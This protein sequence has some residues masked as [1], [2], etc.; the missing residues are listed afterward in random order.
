MKRMWELKQAAEPDM[1]EIFIYG[2]VTDTVIDWVNCIYARKYY[3]FHFKSIDTR[4][5][6]C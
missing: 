3:H 6:I 4:I 1:L 2:D 5:A